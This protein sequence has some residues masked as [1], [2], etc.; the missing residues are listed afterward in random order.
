MKYP[1]SQKKLNGKLIREF[2]VNVDSK[3]LVWH[4]DR[5]NR[6]IYIA[7]GS[8][9]K[10]QLEN[11]L[12]IILKEGSSYKIPKNM[13]HRVLKGQTS[14]VV[15]ITEDEDAVSKI[16]SEIVAKGYRPV[17]FHEVSMFYGTASSTGVPPASDK[18]Q[19]EFHRL[20]DID[21]DLAYEYLNKWLEK[22]GLDR[23]DI[24]D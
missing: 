7:K 9:W 2:S 10:L 21:E 11:T 13:Y 5:N 20:L 12:P 22:Q 15:E 6:Q 4:R 17:G 23:L 24:H 18:E 19:N 14:L 16:I 1:F 3:E 8:G